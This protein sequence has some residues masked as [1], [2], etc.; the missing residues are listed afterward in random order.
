MKSKI[1]KYSTLVCLL[2]SVAWLVSS[3]GWE[4]SIALLSLVAAFIT[5]DE[6]LSSVPKV[7]GRWEYDVVTADLEFSHQG[8]CHIQ[9]EGEKIRVQG[10]RRYTCSLNAGVKICQ[11]V[12]I[13]WESDWAQLCDD[14][15]LRL[16]Y[17]I[18]IAEPQRGGKYIDAICCLKIPS[19][20]P[21]EMSGNY[22]MLPPFDASTLNCKWGTIT[23]RKI[24]EKAKLKPP[25]GYSPRGAV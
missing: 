15:N 14:N 23:F 9:Q 7:E 2:G 10:A 19:K 3:P 21:T 24:D 18:A 5:L 20:R 25:A 17:H 8:D 16:E 22:Y 1:L 6:R 4:P 11:A 13:S 12:N